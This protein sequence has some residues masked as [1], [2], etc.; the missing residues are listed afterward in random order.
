LPKTLRDL[1][2]ALSLSNLCFLGAWRVLVNPLHYTYYHWKYHPGFTEYVALVI[3]VLA[4][5]ALFWGAATLARRSGNRLA[6]KAVRWGFLLALIVPLNDLRMQFTGPQFGNVLGSRKSLLIVLA[7]LLVVAGAA[8][9]RWR[10]HAVRAAVIVVL[11]L[12]PFALISFIQGAWLAIK[13]RPNAALAIDKATR[14]LP[15]PGRTAGARVLWIVFDELDQR[16]AFSARPPGLELPELDRLRGEAVFAERALPPSSDTLFSMP[17]LISGRQIAWAL[18]VR[19]DELLVTAHGSTEEVAWSTQPNVFAE[20]RAAG[21]DTALVGW[22]HPYCRVLADSLSSC[23]WEPVVDEISPLRGEPTLLK[24]MAHWA[25]MSLF[26][27]PGVFR[28]LEPWYESGRSQDHIEEYV[29]IMERARAAVKERGFG[30][31]LL[32]FPI[33]HHPFIYDAAR[34]ALSART[35]DGYAGN[36]LLTDRTLGELRR[37][38]EAAGLWDET[39][40]I[41]S[42]DHWWRTPPD[43]LIDKRVPFIVKLPGQKEGAGYDA[44]FNT[45]LTRALILS[46][47]RGEVTDP[48]GLVRWLDQNRSDA[49]P[50]T[51]SAEPTH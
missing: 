6:M 43:G 50:V 19:P 3:D 45:V 26:R 40:V 44:A 15:E 29:K 39:A 37:E 9:V 27:I 14:P 5:A 42:S 16:R 47:L 21:A 24:S 11:I 31:T 28:L 25:T 13:H 10:A 17:S 46:L 30:L 22:Y 48:P 8:L 23:F 1:I 34:G 51:G 7:A 36:L 4:L 20:A 41:V 32:H 2:V 18:A 35:A 38:M 12:S 33:P 49:Q